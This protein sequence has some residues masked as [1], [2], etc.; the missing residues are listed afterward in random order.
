MIRLNCALLA[1]MFAG[2][3]SSKAQT[4]IA[5]TPEQPATVT[6]GSYSPA[7]LDDPEVK[8]AQALAIDELYGRFSAPATAGRRSMRRS[9]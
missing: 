5:T 1:L 2:A 6:A 7:D 9:S 3:C 4:P 8:A